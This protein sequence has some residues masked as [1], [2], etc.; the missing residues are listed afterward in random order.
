MEHFNQN[1]IGWFTFPRLYKDMINKFPDGSKFVE[2][3]TYEGASFAFFIVEMINAGKHFDVTGVDSFTFAG[4]L[5]K[6]TK[7]MEPVKDKFNV[8][9]DQSWSAADSFADKSV[10]FV[11]IDADHVYENVKKDILAWAPKI[12]PGGVIAG[13]DFVNYHPGVI[14]AVCEIFGERNICRDYLDE[15]CWMMK[16]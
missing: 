4:L 11:F 13:H 10:D 8:I 6:F 12:K 14:Q 15:N 16:L 5:D 1:F 9:I 7:N 2:V 3:G